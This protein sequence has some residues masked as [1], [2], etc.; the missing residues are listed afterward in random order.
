MNTRQ[1]QQS[2]F[3]ASGDNIEVGTPESCPLDPSVLASI[4]EASDYVT[5]SIDSGLTAEVY[6]L[7]INSKK[8]TLK[9]KRVSALVSNVDGKFSFLNEVQRRADFYKLKSN[10][11][12]HELLPNI[13]DTIYA[14]YRLGIILSPWIEGEPLET[15]NKDIFKQILETTSLCEQYG[16]MEWDLCEGNILINEDGKVFLFDFGYMYPFNPLVDINSNGMSDPI[17]HSAERFETR[18][19]FGWLL[20]RNNLSEDDKI[21]LFADLKSVAIDVF[22]KKISWL[23]ANNASPE[24]TQHFQD[25][26]NRWSAAFMSREALR[27]L[28]RAESFR[29]HVLD[30]EDDLHGKSCTSKTLARILSVSDSI[31]NHYEFLKSN[32]CLFYGNAGKSQQ[33]LLETYHQKYKLAQ[34]YLLT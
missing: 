12:D 34:E 28:Y 29:S 22:N 14:N 15:L 19:F 7:T 8:Y 31:T 25:I 4:T 32:D 2:E 26:V 33:D 13:V 6:Q 10:H 20:D 17:F 1:K 9:K 23:K 21:A 30:I 18:F 27:K 3:E 16:L 24:V 11:D 5:K